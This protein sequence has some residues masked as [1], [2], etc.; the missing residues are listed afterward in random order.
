MPAVEEVNRIDQLAGY[1]LAWDLL[2]RQTPQA[3]FFQ[4]LD[5]L[6]SYWQC[7]GPDQKLRVLVVFSGGK[8]IGILPLVVRV[9]RTRVGSIRVL[10]YPLH[11]WGSFYGPIGPNP[12]AT[13][14]V[15]LS[16]VQRTRRDWDLLDLRW[17]NAAGHDMGRTPR[18]MQA[19]G[20]RPHEQPWMQTAV[21]EMSGGWDNYWRG[22]S[23]KFRHNAERLTRRLADQ[24]RLR[25]VRYRPR[26][27]AEGD[28]DP[29][30]DLYESCCRVAK[31]SWQ[32]ASH[33]GTT[34]C[35]GSVSECLRRIHAAAVHAGCLDL[36]LLL[37]D[38]APVAFA[39]NYVY[40]GSVY[41]LR[42]GYDPQWAKFGPGT[43]LQ[44][45]MIEDGFQRGDHLLDLGP[46]SLH[47]KKEWLTSVLTSYR[48]THFPAW[49]PRAQL[50]RLKRL[51]LDRFSTP[52]AVLAAR[53][54]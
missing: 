18:A 15:G 3:T 6:E 4:T 16:H 29:R 23:K 42:K 35:H 39:Y 50:L 37:V 27:A 47:S 28:A 12:T 41:A 30:W 52:E 17:V 38:D 40:R 1:R 14:L 48:Y 11:D 13:L 33:N 24:G 5:W 44:M 26:G 36:N 25:H 34:L 54:S 53:H 43:V 2:L 7:C 45:T 46:G 19:A 8:P 9:E 10:T 20:F 21:V 49:A 32:G 31:T 51:W 22:R